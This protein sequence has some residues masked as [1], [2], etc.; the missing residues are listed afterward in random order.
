MSS[1]YP[2]LDADLV[3]HAL[4]LEDLGPTFGGTAPT[5]AEEAK[6]SHATGHPTKAA[7]HRK[8]AQAAAHGITVGKG[9][10]PLL[11]PAARLQVERLRG[12]NATLHYHAEEVKAQSIPLRGVDLQLRL[13]DNVLRIAPFA[14]TL[15]EGTLAGSATIDVRKRVPTEDLDVRLTNVQLAQFH[16]KGSTMPPLE[17]T[18]VARL[19]VR[20]SGDSMH[21]FASTADGTL[22]VVVPNGEIKQA[23]AEFAGIDV[24]QGLGLM[25]KKNQQQT[26]VRCG[27]AD[28]DAHEGIARVKQVVFDTQVVIVTGKGDVNLRKERLNLQLTGDPKKFRLGVL[29]TPIEIKGTLRHPSIGVKASKLATQGAIA[30]A[31]GAIATPFAAIAAFIDPGL[32]KNADCQALLTDAQ[33]LGAP[34]RTAAKPQRE[35]SAPKKR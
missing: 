6:A 13:R 21:A 10:S 23:F 12:M 9:T 20:G 25:L 11:L 4:N 33:A 22:S 24:V 17:G 15:P 34:V 31:L 27:I 35:A 3:S 26:P 8:V 19:K 1:G 14:F 18:L 29:R 7:T 5:G 2:I 16:A 32:N 30:A 28:F